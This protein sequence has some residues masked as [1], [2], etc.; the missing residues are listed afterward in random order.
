MLY[1]YVLL[2]EYFYLSRRKQFKKLNL[3]LYMYKFMKPL[4]RN[5]KH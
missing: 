2:I 5:G 1:Y 3:T 4:Q